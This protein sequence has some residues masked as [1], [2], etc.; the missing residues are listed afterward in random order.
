MIIIIRPVRLDHADNLEQLD[1]RAYKDYKGKKGDQGEPGNDAKFPLN[2]NY[3]DI[4]GIA[5]LSGGAGSSINI[6]SNVDMN[7]YNSFYNVSSINGY[8]A[9]GQHLA[10]NSPLVCNSTVQIFQDLLNYRLTANK[11][12]KTDSMKILSSTDITIDDVEN[13]STRLTQNEAKTATITLTSTGSA[14]VA[15]NQGASLI[16]TNSANPSL[17]IKGLTSSNNILLIVSS[18]SVDI[19]I[20]PLLTNRLSALEDTKSSSEI[21][22]RS[23]ITTIPN[24]NITIQPYCIFHKIG[25]MVHLCIDRMSFQLIASN[26]EIVLL[27]SIPAPFQPQQNA[28]PYTQ[29]FPLISPVRHHTTTMIINNIARECVLVLSPTGLSIMDQ[30]DG[31]SP[32]LFPVN[33]YIRS[34]GFTFSYSI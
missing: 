5:S 24:C 33:Q 2:L 19:T 25:S 15:P 34:A 23:Y 13:L 6:N 31:V 22:N 28:G 14:F 17:K 32:Y 27:S 11:F 20:D 3:G 21:I 30:Q 12:I 16:P 18:N 7:G 9:I 8:A 1:N 10:I 4:V 29:E 26:I